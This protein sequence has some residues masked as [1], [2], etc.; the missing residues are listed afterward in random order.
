MEIFDYV[1]ILLAAVLLSNLINRFV[2]LLSVPIVQMLLGI[3]IA[4]ISFDFFNEE[5]NLE[6]ELFFVLFLSPLVYQSTMMAD[7][8][9]M[10]NL[11]KP[12]V[13]AAIVLVFVT[14]F[15][16]GYF[17]H[18]LIPSISLAAALAFAA[19]LGPTDVVAVEAVAHRV[20]L[21]RKVMSILS[22]ES[23]IN[24]ATGIV[25]FQFAII[26]AS[27]GSFHI[28]D[29]L[30]RFL[31]L[32]VGGLVVGLILTFIKYMIVRGL[33][34]LDI[35][36]TALHISIG[37]VTPFLIYMISEAVGVSGILAVFAS[38]MAHSIF[39]DK[40]NPEVVK[41]NN[42][43]E[44]VWDVFSFCLDGLVFVI[45][46]TQ[47][48]RIFRVYLTEKHDITGWNIIGY[49]LLISFALMA[50]RF[51]WWMVMVRRKTYDVPENP[52]GKIKSSLI[53]SL[54]GARGAVPLACV[55]TIP[56]LLPNG[57]PFPERDLIIL[58]ASG[59]IIIS[60]LMTNF[61]LPL[62][63][64]HKTETDIET[65]QASRAEI[66]QK[67]MEYLK[68][69]ATPETTAATEIVIR[70]YTS[71]MKQHL[72]SGWKVTKKHTRH[73]LLRDILLWEKDVVLHL[74]EMNQIKETTT[75]HYIEENQVLMAVSRR[76]MKSPRALLMTVWQAIKSFSWKK[77]S[78]PEIKI[79]DSKIILEVATKG[80]T[81]ESR[82]VQQMLDEGR[83]SW[84]TAKEMQA[85]IT[86]LEAQLQAE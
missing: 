67:V 49:V 85:N 30:T 45:L 39:H 79:D 19:A 52:T 83:L 86:V 69:T 58:I 75:E 74:A 23:I 32:A 77:P 5:F 63:A 61:V 33:H 50:V 4:V 73:N 34:L 44:N 66:L 38:G 7:K 62:L 60:L 41:L 8:K 80:F 70:N 76:K 68:N 51:L 24:D 31:I 17:T 40:F 3:L 1:L 15:A 20:T 48:P 59:V 21:P 56:L 72:H 29:G 2:P 81:E 65:E 16:V 37:I 12:I 27:T 28:V 42:A 11:V 35:N 10:G 13:M 6:P 25:C 53:F 26:A 22:G 47:L 82:L 46:G 57:N 71:R 36:N 64:I 84:K 14:I 55:M 54:A 78:R 9:T 18:M 43:Q